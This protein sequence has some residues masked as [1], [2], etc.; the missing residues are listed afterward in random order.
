[1]KSR[2]FIKSFSQLLL[3]VIGILVLQAFIGLLIPCAA[4]GLILGETLV[5]TIVSD[6]M[7]HEAV[8]E[9][10]PG[11]HLAD[12]SE[13]VAELMPAPHP[14]DTL[15]R[16]VRKAEQINS[17]EKK[18]YSVSTKPFKDTFE[19][20][21]SGAGTGYSDSAKSYTYASGNGLTVYYVKTSNP[22]LFNVDDLIMLRNI[23]IPA[24][25]TV[26]VM[27][28]VSDANRVTENIVF[29]VE[30]ITSDTLRIVPLNGIKGLSGNATK[31]VVPDFTDAEYIYILAPAKEE[32]KMKTTP[33]G[34]I[35]EPESNYIQLMMAMVQES[36]WEQLQKKEVNFKFAD[37]ER[38][39]MYALRWQM[40]MNAKYGVKSKT[41]NNETKDY[42]YTSNGITRSITGKLEYGTG[43]GDST[44]SIDQ[45]LGW[46]ESIFVGNNG[47]PERWMLG[48]SGLIKA[49]Q[50][51]IL[52]DTTKQLGARETKEIYGIRC[53]Q[54][55]DFFGTLNIV[56]DPTLSLTGA[57]NEGYILD[58][59]HIEKHD[60]VPMQA[61]EIDLK[62]N[63]ESNSQAK[64]IMEASCLT[65]SFPDTHK[66]I[67]LA[68]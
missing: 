67:T 57:Q 38:Q 52:S 44:L 59:A 32:T 34:I 23:E 47:S 22:A 20:T 50:K 7:T 26:A 29:Y 10:E 15:L 1:M 11:L 66:H 35:P 33:F 4:A 8:V 21:A 37:I 42:H 19:T 53:T 61:R 5:G 49:I 48:G 56:H 28:G 58:L 17:V 62:I 30:G 40:E 12:I 51:M 68:A 9:A 60:F 18:F 43:G 31:Y 24:T 6:G 16:K 41:Y 13:A 39:N 63:G 25:G 46:Q 45:W 2:K 3:V 54:L 27:S 55:Q 14:L 64:V 36:T 65:I